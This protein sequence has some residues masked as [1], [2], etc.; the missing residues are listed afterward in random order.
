MHSDMKTV[1]RQFVQQG[2]SP[3]AKLKMLLSPSLAPELV[4]VAKTFIDL[5]EARHAA[6]YDVS[7]DLTKAEVL[8]QLEKTEAAF[9]AWQTIRKS[10]DARVFITALLINDRWNK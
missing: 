5:Q 1:C 4:V 9:N 6:D 3:P 10:M 8:S 2:N 7:T